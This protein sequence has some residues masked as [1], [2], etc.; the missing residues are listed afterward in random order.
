MLTVRVKKEC[1]ESTIARIL[2]LIEEAR[3]REARA[4]RFIT[5]FAR[6][7]TPIVISL[8]CLIAFLPP[9]FMGGNLKVWAY[10]ALV[11]LIVSCPCALVLS[12]PLTYF[13]GLGRCAK[14]GIL[15]KGANYLDL[16]SKLKAM[17][18]E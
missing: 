10:R 11:I 17:A 13:A 16:L 14:E 18:L 12:I 8:A 6:Y 15:V 5:T 2:K 7:Y 1:P 4:E 9:L 3:A